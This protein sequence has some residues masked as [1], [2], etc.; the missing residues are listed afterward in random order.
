MENTAIKNQL[1]KDMRQFYTL[2]LCPPA[3]LQNWIAEINMWSPRRNFFK[4]WRI[5]STGNDPLERLEVL[6]DWR[7]EGGI[8]L[9]G[10][11]MFQRF[12]KILFE[13]RELK[14]DGME[15]PMKGLS[16]EDM[17]DAA[18]ILTQ[19]PNIVVADEAHTLKNER[20]LISKAVRKF[21]TKRRIAL[22]GTP[23]SNNTQEIFAAIDWVAPNFL[24]P[25][26]DFKATFTGPI[27]QGLWE[28][29]TSS[30]RRKSKIQLTA[31]NS[32][33]APKINRADITALKGS[34][35]PK[36][37]FVLKIPLTKLQQDLYI[38]MIDFFLGRADQIQGQ[39]S[40][41]LFQWISQLTALVVDPLALKYKLEMPI[42]SSKK[43][44]QK[45]KDRD[46]DKDETNIDGSGFVEPAPE[47][48]ELFGDED[49]RDMGFTETFI[50]EVL[51]VI[52]EKV[53]MLDLSYRI[54]LTQQI[55]YK[56]RA[57]GD[58]LL[59]FSQWI[60]TLKSMG[61]V[62]NN[63]S[64]NWALI[65]GSKKMADRD[66]ILADFKEGRYDV[67]LISTRAGGQG[68]NMQT[69]NRVVLLDFS[70]NPTW[71][72][73][74]V[75][76]AYRFG[77][78]KPVYVYR[79]VS[80]GT[81]EE[82]LYKMNMFKSS[83]F[84]RVVDKKSPTRIGAQ[85][86]LKDWL[87]HPREVEQGD[88]E[89]EFGKDEQVLDQI[90]KSKTCV[91]GSLIR[92]IKT[93][94][95]LQKEDGEAPLDEQEQREVEANIKEMRRLRERVSLPV[96][97]LGGLPV[98]FSTA[99]AGQSVQR[100]WMPVASTSAPTSFSK[101]I[102]GV[103]LQDHLDQTVKQPI[104]PK[105]P[106]GLLPTNHHRDASQSVQ[107]PGESTAPSQNGRR[108]S[109]MNERP[110]EPRKIATNGSNAT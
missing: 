19:T 99:P 58:K 67:V 95:T 1:P 36:T 98:P 41:L 16:V 105:T 46:M 6:Q 50:Q 37:E 15:K 11:S 79:F 34:L 9:I 78:T 14:A 57:V 76:R 54:W 61:R 94:E 69:A 90:L 62:L 13:Q 100:P 73:Q 64:I 72:E 25:A 97:P 91:D 83:L 51:A 21:K 80:G 42:K 86:D 81:F 38:M 5:D 102:K 43:K 85:T 108:A 101:S 4:V 74:A 10:Y 28:D 84:S 24:G 65:D 68:L 107:V 88:I 66:R 33:I 40:T 110:S 56:S 8:L 109:V 49:V 7:E 2:I 103:I 35:K 92:S 23:M 63:L 96:A 71:E 12:T 82:R 75:G 44:K 29:S 55:I 104:T 3:V 106:F 70:W 89:S 20:A 22:T 77:Q 53:I 47:E 48:D 60:P 26:S 32:E 31:L 17:Q 27:E 52:P 18:K 39:Q 30:E 59:I 93:M 87:F 45:L